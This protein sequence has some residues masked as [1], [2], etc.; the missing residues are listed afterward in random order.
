MIQMKTGFHNQLNRK[1][2]D[3]KK[4]KSKQYIFLVFFFQAMEKILK[5]WN[6]QLMIHRLFI[7]I[8]Y[9]GGSTSKA[10]LKDKTRV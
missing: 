9:I 4:G 3:F 7:V 2:R 8:D 1:W 6:S 5:P 10:I